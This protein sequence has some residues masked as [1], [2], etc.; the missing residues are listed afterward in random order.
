MYPFAYAFFHNYRV[1]EFGSSIFPMRNPY[2]TEEELPKDKEL[3]IVQ[4]DIF[5]DNLHFSAM[6]IL[7]CTFRT[8]SV[9]TSQRVDFLLDYVSV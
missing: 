1:G 5:S 7:W 2:Q 4:A 3:Q 6:T 8:L 9:A